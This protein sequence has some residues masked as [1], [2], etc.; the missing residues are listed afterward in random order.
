[1]VDLR[2][3]RERISRMVYVREL[4][5]GEGVSDNRPDAVVIK[6]LEWQLKARP[7]ESTDLIWSHALTRIDSRDR[8]LE[9]SAPP[10]TS[11]LTWLQRYPRGFASTVSVIN[12]GPVEW[13]DSR[14][15]KSYTTWDARLAWR[16]NLVAGAGHRAAQ[17]VIEL[18][19]GHFCRAAQDLRANDQRVE[20][21]PEGVQRRH[22]PRPVQVPRRVRDEVAV[23]AQQ[24][25]R[26]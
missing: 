4:D 22:A 18:A 7:M 2:A 25:R 17:L 21:I 9:A 6:G 11:T 1:M 26:L 12:V 5:S 14:R 13:L 10:Y 15:V 16:F 3:Y 19:E 24:R 20:Q 8:D 23:Q